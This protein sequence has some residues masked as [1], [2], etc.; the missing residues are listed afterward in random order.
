MAVGIQIYILPLLHRHR[1][2]HPLTRSHPTIPVVSSLPPP[3]H[4]PARRFPRRRSRIAKKQP[5]VRIYCSY[6]NVD[7]SFAEFRVLLRFK[8]TYS[9]T[10]AGTHSCRMILLQGDKENVRIFRAMD[11][12]TKLPKEIV[13]IAPTNRG[14]KLFS[15]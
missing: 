6:C 13:L 11:D 4:P 12:G 10:Y 3:P 8:R 15:L 5:R 9:C 1:R 7:E 2:R 14:N